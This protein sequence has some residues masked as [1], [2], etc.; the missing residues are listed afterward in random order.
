MN[1]DVAMG[2]TFFLGR[3]RTNLEF[4]AS[5]FNVANR[6]LLGSLQTSVTSNTYGRFSNP[7][8]NQPRN[9]QFSLR[10]SF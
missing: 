4:R 5:A 2:K 1:E 6:H 10:L 8:A 7:Q 3:E 9:V